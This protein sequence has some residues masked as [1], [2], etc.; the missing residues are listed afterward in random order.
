MELQLTLSKRSQ[1]QG[2]SNNTSSSNKDEIQQPR[3]SHIRKRDPSHTPTTKHT[4]RHVPFI[5][6]EYTKQIFAYVKT[7]TMAKWLCLK[8]SLTGQTHHP[9]P[10]PSVNK[11]ILF[12][13]LVSVPIPPTFLVAQAGQNARQTH[14]FIF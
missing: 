2:N 13:R 1:V 8:L 14:K 5:D 9:T 7:R 3:A 11:H 10:L 12:M 6:L 4:R